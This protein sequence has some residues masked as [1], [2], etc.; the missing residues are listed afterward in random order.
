MMLSDVCLCEICLTLVQ[1]L[2][3]QLQVFIQK[4]YLKGPNW[5][6]MDALLSSTEEDSQSIWLKFWRNSGELVR[7]VVVGRLVIC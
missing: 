6:R 5:V 1:A 3:L 4:T 7:D 2:F